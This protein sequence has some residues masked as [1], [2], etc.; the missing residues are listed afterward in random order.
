MILGANEVIWDLTLAFSSHCAAFVRLIERPVSLKTL[1]T[2][3]HTHHTLYCLCCSVSPHRY[4]TFL[5][6]F[7]FPFS[8]QRPQWSYGQ[9]T[10]KIVCF[11]WPAG[12]HWSGRTHSQKTTHTETY[13]T[14]SERPLNIWGRT[15]CTADTQQIQDR[16]M[17]GDLCHDNREVFP[18][19]LLSVPSVLNLS[20]RQYWSMWGE[21][22]ATTEQPL[23]KSS[24]LLASLQRAAALIFNHM[25]RCLLN[26]S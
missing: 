3:H 15:G 21:D 19:R 16:C 23:L 10:G 5:I 1:D 24:D 14:L 4:Y 25:V 20:F 26:S 7:G 12:S 13:W 11:F 9:L 22:V 6:Y 8:C 2:F 18:L 17:L